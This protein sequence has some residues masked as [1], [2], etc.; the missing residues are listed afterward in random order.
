M[1][2]AMMSVAEAARLIQRGTVAVIAG[3]EEALS[4][5]PHGPWIGSTSVYFMSNGSPRLDRRQV[6]VTTFPAARAV[7]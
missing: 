6:F 1:K 5:L 4:Q 3:S 2:N 7:A